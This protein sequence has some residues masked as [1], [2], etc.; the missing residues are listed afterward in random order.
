[1]FS[2]LYLGYLSDYVAAGWGLG[3]QNSK[4]EKSCGTDQMKKYRRKISHHNLPNCDL[5]GFL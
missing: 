3:G 2:L 5:T 1:M 4:G